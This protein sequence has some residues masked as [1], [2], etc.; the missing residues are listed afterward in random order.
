ADTTDR[1]TMKQKL[2]NDMFHN[3]SPLQLYV[4]HTEAT[5]GD[6]GNGWF[7]SWL[8]DVTN[9]VTQRWISEEW[10]PSGRLNIIQGDYYNR[11]CLVEI[12][13]MWNSH[14]AAPLGCYAWPP[15]GLTMKLPDGTMMPNPQSLE[16][17]Q[18]VW[19]W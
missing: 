9:P 4:L 5:P 18:R 8:A 13:L 14:H 3:N 7:P 11:S 12:A 2:L 17:D 16:W 6:D 1:D 10:L 15:V 19:N